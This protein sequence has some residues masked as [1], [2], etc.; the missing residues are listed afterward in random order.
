MLPE[1]LHGFLLDVDY[2]T[3]ENQSHIRLFVRT[4][5][6]IRVLEDPNFHPYY[7]IELENAADVQRV[8][9]AAQ[10]ENKRI[11]KIEHKPRQNNPNTYDISF[12]KVEDLVA[13]RQ[14]SKSLGVVKNQFEDNIVFAKRYLIDTGLVPFAGIEIE[15]KNNAI[16]NAS[17]T[18]EILSPTMLTFDLE[19][20]SPDRFPDPKKTPSS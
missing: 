12:Y 1:R 6:G 5:T 13:F 16:Q 4:P 10:R 15:T 19:T 20:L 2:R 11:R 7:A 9:E 17:T 3:D 18:G 14:T 8:T